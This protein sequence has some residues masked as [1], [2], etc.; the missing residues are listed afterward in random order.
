[1]FAPKSV[2]ITGTNRSLGLALVR[3]LLELASPP[4]HIFAC[5]RTPHNAEELKCVANENP[6][7]IVMK[8]DPGW[9]AKE[10]GGGIGPTPPEE[11][12]KALLKVFATGTE[13]HQGDFY[14]HQGEQLPF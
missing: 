12:A 3:Q 14:T 11:S 2:L 10:I 7:V 9:L 1:M 13:A 8:L 5:C 6:S 4:N